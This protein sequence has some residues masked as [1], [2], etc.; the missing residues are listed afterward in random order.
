MTENQRLRAI[1][2]AAR[3]TGDVPAD[4]DCP[5]CQET[6]GRVGEQGPDGTAITV[7]CPRCFPPPKDGPSGDQR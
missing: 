4:P 6:P 3:S 7:E 1:I 5:E 2:E